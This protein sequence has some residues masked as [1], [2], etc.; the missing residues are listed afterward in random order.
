MDMEH[1]K[2][3]RVSYINTLLPCSWTVQRDTQPEKCG[4]LAVPCTASV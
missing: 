3:V 4:L 1:T 2:P